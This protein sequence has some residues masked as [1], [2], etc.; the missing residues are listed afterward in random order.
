[1]SGTPNIKRPVKQTPAT[2][3]GEATCLTCGNDPSKP[4]NDLEV[5]EV[6]P[7]KSLERR[8]T[9]VLK[10]RV[11]L[12]LLDYCRDNKVQPGTAIKELVEFRLVQLGKLPDWWYS[13]KL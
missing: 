6:I 11:L 10:D 8:Y 1:M 9:A 12:G 3:R 7:Y 2:A 13:R 4:P 5:K